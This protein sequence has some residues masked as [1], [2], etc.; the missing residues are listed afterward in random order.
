MELKFDAKFNHPPKHK[1]E[2]STPEELVNRLSVLVGQKFP[3]KKVARTD[4]SNVRKLVA[5]TLSE[6]APEKA[7]K[8]E[9]NVVPEKGKGVPKNLLEYVDSYIVTSGNVYNLQVWNRNPASDSVQVEYINGDTLSAND[10]RFVTVKVNTETHIIESVLVLSPAYIVEKFGKFGKPTVKSQMI[11][12][13][14]ARQKVINKPSRILFYSSSRKIGDVKNID[15]LHKFSIKDEP[16]KQSLLP[17]ESL[18]DVIATKIV[19]KVSVTPSLS[20]KE[21]GQ[22]L[23]RIIATS[24]GYNINEAELM[25]GGYPDIRNQALEIKVQDSPTVDLGKY[26]PEFEVDVPS[27]PGFSTGDIRYFIALTN[28]TSGLV[29]GAVLCEGNKLGHH[30]TYIGAE[31]YKCQRTI[32]MTYFEKYAGQ[33]LYNPE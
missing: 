1:N 12:S 32:P 17:I 6:G 3:F 26:T 31:S 18:L 7:A 33:T 8:P 28:P 22:Y 21:R 2:L 9:F 23:E 16:T 27:C 19:G 13:N 14:K 10:V 4:G 29:E 11:I 15:N 20:T 5:M 25:D 30:F 24:L